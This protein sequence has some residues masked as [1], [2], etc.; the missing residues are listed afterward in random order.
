MKVYIVGGGIAGLT[1]YLFLKKRFADTQ[2]PLELRIFESHKTTL[3]PSP[4]TFEELSSSTAIVGGGL[5]ITPNGM[6]VLLDLDKDIHDAV[7]AQGFVCENFVFKAARGFRLIKTPTKDLKE[8]PEYCVSSSRQ[9]LWEVLRDAVGFDIVDYRRVTQVLV[10]QYGKPVLRFADGSPDEEADL[11][12]GA[13]GVRS[14]VKKAVFG[15]ENET[16]YAPHFEDM[17]GVGG[18][19]DMPIPEEIQQDKSMLHYLGPNGSFGVAA[20]SPTSLMWWST[21]ETAQLP[22]SAKLDPSELKAQLVARHKNWKDPLIHAIIESVE[23][24]SVYPVWTTPPLPFW[25]ADRCILIGDAAHALQPYSGQGAS[26]ALEDAQTLSLL[27]S[28]YLPLVSSEDDAERLEP[29]GAIAAATKAFYEVRSPRVD[30]IVEFTKK[31]G[32]V[33]RDQNVVQEFMVYFFFWV[34]G[35]FPFMGK[36]LLGD[37]NEKL[38][39]WNAYEEVEKYLNRGK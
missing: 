12:V 20:A 18:F 29:S 7:V 22:S 1:T 9:G 6:R 28:K 33:K 35:Q 26:Q 3:T 14:T 17:V 13:D 15:E 32:S 30:A 4:T 36:L 2:I 37:Y 25:G 27:L 38:A 10:D 23:V 8:P 24:D 11:V 5:G 31:I 39:S 16:L 19:V 34:M 21:N